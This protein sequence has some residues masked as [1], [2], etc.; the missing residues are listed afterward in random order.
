MIK[1]LDELDNAKKTMTFIVIS[2]HLLSL[3]VINGHFLY[4]CVRLLS[5]I[6]VS[7]SPEVNDLEYSKAK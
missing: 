6:T 4:F 7:E 5:N 2:S 3:M 1:G